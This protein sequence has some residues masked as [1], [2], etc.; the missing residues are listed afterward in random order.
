[1]RETLIPLPPGERV[2]LLARL[3]RPGVR[4]SKVMAQSRAGLRVTV[5]IM[6]LASFPLG[7]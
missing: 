3:V 7:L 2:W 1:M 6:G 4:E 5:Q